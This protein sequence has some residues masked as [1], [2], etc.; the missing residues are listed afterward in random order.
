MKKYIVVVV[1]VVVVIAG[2]MFMYGPA[3]RGTTGLAPAQVPAMGTTSGDAVL[4]GEVVETMNAGGYTYLNVKTAQG[5]V[6]AAGPETPVKAGD[7]VAMPAG[8]KMEN[9]T[10]DT[11]DRTFDAVYF[12]PE[13]RVGGAPASGGMPTGHPQ[14]GAGEAT[15][16]DLSGIE[17]PKGGKSIAEI[18]AAKK[19]VSGKEV[20][21]RGKVVKFTPGVMGKNWI[22]LRDGTGAEGTNDLTVTTD[23]TVKIGNLIVARGVVGIDKDLGFGYQYEI[24]VED[25][26]ITVE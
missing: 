11:L 4:A 23:A 7:V 22:H 18:Y 6:W 12:V 19:D 16:I 8:M 9:F 17:V 5:E 26:K 20:V 2:I 21:V 1:A 25:A 14:V 13:I 24:I 10:S 3:K 15:D